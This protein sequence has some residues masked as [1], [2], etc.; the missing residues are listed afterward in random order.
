MHSY[1]LILVVLLQFMHATILSAGTV[2][3]GLPHFSFVHAAS[4]VRLESTNFGQH[5][6]GF[7]FSGYLSG[8]LSLFHD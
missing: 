2:A 7:N 1:F 3:T 6:F 8:Y 4:I 5:I